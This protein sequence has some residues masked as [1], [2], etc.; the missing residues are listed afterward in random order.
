VKSALDPNGI[1]A[2][3]KQGVWPAVFRDWAGK[4]EVA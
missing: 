4:G 2:P 3:G 1:L